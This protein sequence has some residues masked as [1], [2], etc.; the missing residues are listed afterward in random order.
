I[1]RV[2]Y[3]IAIG[4]AALA[5]FSAQPAVAQN[6]DTSRE[7]VIGVKDAPP[8]AMKDANGEWTGLS[9]E[10]WQKIAR[11]LHL[12]YRFAEAPTVQDLLDSTEARK[13]DAGLGAITV[14]AEREQ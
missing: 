5:F 11:D 14:T 4:V 9:I 10:L 8:F 7:L 2:F 13:Y 1:S 6:P 12:K 3:S